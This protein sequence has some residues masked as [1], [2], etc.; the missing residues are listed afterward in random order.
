MASFHVWPIVAFP[1]KSEWR[2]RVT[3]RAKWA[4]GTRTASWLSIERPCRCSRVYKGEQTQKRTVPARDNPIIAALRRSL[5][6]S[7]SFTSLLDV[8]RP[9]DRVLD[10]VIAFVFND[11][12]IREI[13]VFVVKALLTD[14]RQ[15]V[16][17][18][19]DALKESNHIFRRDRELVLRKK[20]VKYFPDLFGSGL[21]IVAIKREIEKRFNC[22]NKLPQHNWNR[23]RKALSL[24]E[25]PTG[26][27]KKSDTK[28]VK[29]VSLV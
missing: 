19:R 23:L 15:I 13:G 18:V 22:G 4:N 12:T 25:L 10:P 29:T 24:V 9:P 11:A 8:D 21:G 7:G 16:R 26:R 6:G 2:W 1:K 20:V 27:P 28:R 17:T 3:L 5:P 14:D